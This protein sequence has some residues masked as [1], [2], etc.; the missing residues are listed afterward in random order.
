MNF[1][2]KEVKIMREWL[3][4]TLSSFNIVFGFGC[5]QATGKMSGDYKIEDVHAVLEKLQGKEETMR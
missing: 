2:D 4:N 5:L 1:N 3:E